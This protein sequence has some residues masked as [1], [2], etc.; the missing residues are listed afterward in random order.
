MLLSALLL[1]RRS[2]RRHCSVKMAALQH[3]PVFIYATAREPFEVRKRRS[4]NKRSFIVFLTLVAPIVTRAALLTLKLN[5]TSVII[6]AWLS[7]KP[8][9]FTGWIST[10]KFVV[11]FPF[12][13]VFIP[14][15]V[16]GGLLQPI[17]ASGERAIMKENRGFQCNPNIWCFTHIII[18]ILWL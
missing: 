9:I 2:V 3:W 7:R 11:S 16:T 6:N 1:W 8:Q 17:P 13:W 15:G 4:Q 18:Y 5:H 12:L 10:P 14:L